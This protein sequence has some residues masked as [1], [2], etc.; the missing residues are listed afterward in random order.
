MSSVPTVAYKAALTKSHRITVRAEVLRQGLKI[1]DLGITGGK[2]S[3]SRT[4]AAR[5]RCTLTLSDAT[6]MPKNYSDLL[7]PAGNEVKVYRGIAGVQEFS[8]GVFRISKPSVDDDGIPLVTLEGI[9]RARQISRTLNSAPISIVRN[10]LVHVA[11]KNV[12]QARVPWMTD[13]MFNFEV[14]AHTHPG[15]WI[16]PGDNIWKV[17]NDMAIAAG[18][19]LY[20]DNEGLC[21][22]KTIEDPLNSAT[23]WDLSEGQASTTISVKRSIDDEKAINGYVVSAQNSGNTAPITASSWDTDPSS[24]TYYL[25]PFGQQPEFIQTDQVSTLSQAQAMAD[26]LKRKNI[27]FLESVSAMCVPNPAMTESDVL[28]IKRNAS[29]IDYLGVAESLEIPLGLEED[30]SITMRARSL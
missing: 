14:T 25:G 13:S 16:M 15:G 28:Y 11:I 17:V 8:L 9:D 2:V 30:M 6:L 4:Q 1:A 5:R 29:G 24:P 21:T 18:M 23:D 7:W 10:T 12:I 26:G 20:F 22:L 19:E 27:G 3:V